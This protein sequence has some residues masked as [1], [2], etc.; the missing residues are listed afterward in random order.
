[1][2]ADC[3]FVEIDPALIYYLSYHTNECRHDAKD[4]LCLHST[5]IAKMASKLREKIVNLVIAGLTST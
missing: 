1:M 2:Q 5:V 3:S 4:F